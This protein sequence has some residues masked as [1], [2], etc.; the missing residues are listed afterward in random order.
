MRKSR[1]CQ[2]V[3]FV[4]LLALGALSPQIFKTAKNAL[5]PDNAE[6]DQPK[7]M[8]YDNPTIYYKA[9]ATKVTSATSVAIHYHNDDKLCATRE[10]WVWCNGV[11]GSAFAPTSVSSD[12]KD[13]VLEFSFT[14]DHANFANKKGIYFIVKFQN[15]WTGQSE[16][17]YVDYAEFL[18]YSWRR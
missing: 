5:E 18:V 15:T 4:S 1:F 6:Y 17:V 8:H 13:M 7:V 9:P 3:A 11:N 10:F 12:G 16:N 14:G 2:G